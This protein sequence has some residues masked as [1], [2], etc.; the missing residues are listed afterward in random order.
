MQKITKEQWERLGEK[1]EKMTP[2][3]KAKMQKLQKKIKSLSKEELRELTKIPD[4][5]LFI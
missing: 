2:E 3:E 5:C 4:D 1:S